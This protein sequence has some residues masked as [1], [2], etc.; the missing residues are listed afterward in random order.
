MSMQTLAQR[1]ARTSE[2]SAR[3]CKGRTL[4]DMGC[5]SSFTHHM[6]VIAR[7]GSGAAIARLEG[8]CSSLVPRIPSL[9]G[10]GAAVACSGLCKQQLESQ[11]IARSMCRHFCINPQITTTHSLFLE[12]RDYSD[13][14]P[15]SPQLSGWTRRRQGACISRSGEAQMGMCRCLHALNCL[16]RQL[17]CLDAQ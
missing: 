14:P 10:G 6:G 9:E 2:Y 8:N 12:S 13:Y 7:S 5:T 17:S 15:S 1:T 11:S 4:E 16:A 3:N